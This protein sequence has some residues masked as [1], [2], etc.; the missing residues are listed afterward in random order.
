MPSLGYL[1]LLLITTFLT[2]PTLAQHPNLPTKNPIARPGATNTYPLLSHPSNTLTVHW[3]TNPIN[4]Y[5]L[6]AYT[7]FDFQ[8]HLGGL[9]PYNASD[10]RWTDYCSPIDI[11]NGDAVSGAGCVQ[12]HIVPARENTDQ[13][14]D[15]GLLADVV[16]TIRMLA[17]D[18]PVVWTLEAE[19]T[20]GPAGAGEK[21]VGVGFVANRSSMVGSGEGLGVRA[22]PIAVP[23]M[24]R[25]FVG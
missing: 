7:A 1:P 16:T 15:V 8:S 23:R 22:A 14:I 25:A 3:G 18:R 13:M 4:S 17:L 21:A 9:G 10:P 12:L 6:Y 20:F 2:P 5:A 19:F 11:S 24:A